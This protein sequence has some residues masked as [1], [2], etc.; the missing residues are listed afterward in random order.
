MPK[1]RAYTE[2]VEHDLQYCQSLANRAVVALS[3]AVTLDATL[4]DL[5]M[6]AAVWQ[7]HFKVG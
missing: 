5:D 6:L 7:G 3:M 1:P 4:I 2:S